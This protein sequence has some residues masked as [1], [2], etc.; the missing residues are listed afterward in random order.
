MGQRSGSRANTAIALRSCGRDEG[1]GTFAGWNGST[2]ERRLHYLVGMTLQISKNQYVSSPP[3]CPT[4]HISNYSGRAL[5]FQYCRNGVAKLSRWLRACT[6]DTS[7]SKGTGGQRCRE[8][9]PRDYVLVGSE[10]LDDSRERISRFLVWP[11]IDRCPECQ[12]VSF[13]RS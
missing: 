7:G 5:S 13:S 11:L 3:F 12:C 6:R 4:K 8:R 9:L 2:G 10:P 1:F